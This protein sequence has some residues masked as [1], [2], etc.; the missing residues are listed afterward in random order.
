MN[1]LYRNIITIFF[2][3]T[4]Q[5]AIAQIT[6]QEAAQKIARGINLGNTLEPPTEGAWNNGAVQK[7]YFDDY[8]NA[9]FACVRI[10]VRWDEHTETSSPFRIDPAWMN[11]VEEVVDWGLS[12]GLYIIINSH[13]DNW[14]KDNYN[15][16]NKERFDSIWSQISFRFKRKSDKLFFEI[17]NEPI[18]L[19]VEQVDD[20]NQRELSIIRKKNPTRIV[21]YSGNE[22]SALDRLMEAKIPNDNYVIA[23]FHMYDPW[24]FAG[25]GNGTW[26]SISDINKIKS[27][28]ATAHNW[29]VSNNI[30]VILSE[31]GAIKKCDY[32]SRM[33]FYSTYVEQALKN[34]IPFMVWDDGGNFQVYERA[35]RTWN[36][37]KDILIHTSEESPV[38]TSYKIENDLSITIHWQQNTNKNILTIVERKTDGEKFLLFAELSS[39]DT[40]FNDI[41]IEKNKNYY[42]RIISKINDT[43]SYYSYP[44]KI[45]AKPIVRRPY[46][47]APFAIPD[48]IEAEY[49][50]IGGEGLT[51]HDTEQLN[52]P[53]AFRT[54]EWVDIEARDSG[55]YQIAYVATG[56]WLEYTITVPDSGNYNITAFVASKN[57]GGKIKF[58]SGTN[59]SEIIDIPSTNSWQSTT[60]VKGNIFLPQGKQILRMNIVLANPFNIDKFAI[61]RKDT[62]TSIKSNSKNNFVYELY[63]NYPNPFNPTTTIKF[64]IPTPLP[65]ASLRDNP[66]FAKV[67]NT[68]WFVTLK[69]YDILGKE[70]ATL[71]NERKRPGEYTITFDGSN[72]S[73]GIY[74]YQ[75]KTNG[76][77]KTKKMLLLQ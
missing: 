52:I 12:R 6:P 56:E 11:R 29:S 25:K 13:H 41:G 76:F 28:F 38:I 60:K 77:I 45:F 7:Y 32:N 39:T 24:N 46:L 37:I 47:A 49:F 15:E 70:V 30:P 71:V 35:A 33:L 17:I 59:S 43:V 42:Y 9:G 61:T 10:P 27:Q 20:L 22:W 58:T 67:R 18:G 26:G 68:G 3:F 57:G 62:S 72:L 23:Y 40:T 16:L 74:Y 50:D 69:V 55:G 65:K 63:Q 75:I 53:G 4:F 36:E 14:I 44:V 73:S 8:N 51:Y 66:P 64:I 19:T 31:F 54:E 21:I 1:T 48:T 34:K 2:L 5:L